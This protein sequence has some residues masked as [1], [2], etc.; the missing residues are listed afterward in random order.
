MRWVRKKRAG[1]K[2]RFT[3]KQLRLL[4]RLLMFCWRTH[5]GKKARKEAFNLLD[6][7]QAELGKDEMGRSEIIKSM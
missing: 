2:M 3:N 4:E 1:E 7:V 6:I 5:P